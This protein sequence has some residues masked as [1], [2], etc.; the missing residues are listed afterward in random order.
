MKTSNIS[1]SGKFKVK[2]GKQSIRAEVVP[3]CPD[4]ESPVK[5]TEEFV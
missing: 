1:Q 5:Y 3:L 2:S 4:Y